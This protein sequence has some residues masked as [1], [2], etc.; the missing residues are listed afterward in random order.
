MKSKSTLFVICVA[1]TAWATTLAHAEEDVLFFDSF[2]SGNMSTTN[3]S[4]FQWGHVNRTSIVTQSETDGNVIIYSP[5]GEEVYDI[6]NDGKDWTAFDGENSLR[7]RYPAGVN[8]SEQ[9]FDMGDAY[10]EL[11]IS[12]WLRVPTN[13]SH[14]TENPT[15]HKLFA[16]WMDGY[17][18][19][20]DGPT[21]IWEFWN[22]GN[23]GSNLAV[24]YSEGGFTGA[25]GHLQHTPFISYPT[26][27]GR[28]M[29]IVLNIKAATNKT[30]N[31][32]II[33][34]WRLWAGETAY[35][36][37]HNISD[38]NIAIPEGGPN[39]W[40][41]GYIMGWSNPTY[42]NDT[43][44]LLDSFTVSETMLLDGSEPI[45]PPPAPPALEL[46]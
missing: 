13:F 39:G 17:D 46:E 41:A 29:H 2:E 18:T 12:F 21:I 34:M 37:F 9:R 31:D 40:A 36:Q 16:L 45:K 11:W 28:W 24:H 5:T 44:W 8:W 22:N 25:G 33:K 10:P 30:S 42:D 26:D 35:S 4:G 43:E 20:G 14:G 23:N 15:N 27:Q 38:A 19:K 3:A 6:Q 32:G 7:F 1:A